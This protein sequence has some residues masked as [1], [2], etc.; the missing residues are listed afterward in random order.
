MPCVDA[1]AAACCYRSL[2][3]TYGASHRIS[4]VTV[5]VPHTLLAYVLRS[6][7]QPTHVILV[8]GVGG[9]PYV[10]HPHWEP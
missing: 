8:G 10:R 5:Y 6:V 2:S 1:A 4:F 9:I 7:P 3:N